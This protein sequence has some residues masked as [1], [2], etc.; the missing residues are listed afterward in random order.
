MPLPPPTPAKIKEIYDLNP[1]AD[2][3][4][5]VVQYSEDGKQDF[6]CVTCITMDQWDEI[7]R[8]LHHRQGE[9]RR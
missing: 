3:V 2:S 9:I 6:A 1:G 5:Y 4:V 7:F 8:I